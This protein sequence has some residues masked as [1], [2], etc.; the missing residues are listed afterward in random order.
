MQVTTKIP[1]VFEMRVR[2]SGAMNLFGL[3]LGAGF[4]MLA[5]GAWLTIAQVRVNGPHY[6]RIHANEVLTADILPPPLFLVEYFLANSQFHEASDLTSAHDI[7][8]SAEALGE[9]PPLVK[10]YKERVAYWRAN[11]KASPAMTLLLVDSDSKAQEMFRLSDAMVAARQAGDI[12][13]EDAAFTR[14][15]DVYHE[16]LAL[17]QKA[18]PM[19]TAEREAAEAESDRVQAIGI[20]AMFALGALMALIIVGGIYILRRRVVRP[21]EAITRYMGQLADGHYEGKVPFLGREDELGDMAKSVATFREGVLERRTLREQSEADRARTDTA[22]RA[23]EAARK[24]DSDR[25]DQAMDRLASGLD[26]L[27]AGDVAHRIEEAF[28]PEYERLRN[29]FNAAASRLSQ[30]LRTIRASADG[31]GSGA[32]EIARASDDLS[33]RTEQQA[34][35][36]EQ[37]AAALDE[38]TATVRQTAEGAATA[39]RIVGET[40]REAQ[41][42]EATVAETI[43][44]VSDIEAAS[45]QI[46]QIIGVIDEIAFQTNL[47]ALN[48][49]VEA[50]RA[51]DA[52]KGFA[53]VAQEVRGLAQRSAEAAKEIKGLISASSS[54]V[55]EGVNLVGQT[56]KSLDAI[57]NRVGDIARVVSE[58]SASAQEQSMGLAEVNNAV[59]HMDQ[60]T[61]RNAAMVEQTT[62]AAHT[63]RQEAARLNDAVGQFQLDGGAGRSTG[64]QRAVA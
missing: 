14:M 12:A 64:A 44:A 41:S 9:M 21:V 3:F 33:R 52:G 47:L 19:I 30:T 50:A 63:L 58:I 45:S 62:A 5:L 51:G 18:V 22:R 17:I 15:H 37:T 10:G 7:E 34:A 32:D 60:T 39:D 61:Q 2:L 42:T 48:A 13:A 29:D 35:A 26:H 54:K 28:A 20:G 55:A 53:V 23:D 43:R 8:E 4:L 11:G 56:G 27:S 31:V 24:A 57:L 46:T 6:E 59:N 1:G 38:I 49:G 16:H 40:R 36:L 25:R